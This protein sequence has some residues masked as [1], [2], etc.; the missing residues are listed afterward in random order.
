MQG[1]TLLCICRENLIDFMGVASCLA[2]RGTMSERLTDKLTDSVA[3][4]ADEVLE[5]W[6]SYQDKT[7]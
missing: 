1:G 6:E 2:S 3:G 4:M 5:K 7:E